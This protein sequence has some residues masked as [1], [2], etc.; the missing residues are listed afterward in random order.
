[1][2]EALFTAI[3]AGRLI[4]ALML[5]RRIESHQPIAGLMA[6]IVIADLLDGVEARQ[7]DADGPVRRVA[8][9]LVDMVSIGLGMSALYRSNPTARPYILALAARETFVS[10]GN[11]IN[12]A[13]TGEVLKGDN[14]HK[15]ASLSIASYALAANRGNKTATH[16]TG[17]MAVAINYRLAADYYASWKHPQRG[18][19]LERGLREVPGFS[20]LGHIR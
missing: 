6:G 15:L 5:S 2:K 7:H 12:Y 3:T 9:S 8:D 20:K 4:P 14:L 16:A 19:L 17:L 18:R 1:M 11:T 10:V 13:K